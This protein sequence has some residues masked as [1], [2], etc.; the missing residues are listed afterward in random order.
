VKGWQWRLGLAGVIVFAL[1]AVMAS[2]EEAAIASVETQGTAFAVRL[3]DGRVL[4]QQELVGAVLDVSDDR[5]KSLTVRIDGF[6]IDPRDPEQEVVLYRLMVLGED[7]T[8]RELCN[9]DPAGERWAFPLAGVWTAVSE[10]Q[11]DPRAFNVTCSSGAIGKC[12]RLGYKPWKQLPDG[13]ALWDY[14]QAC[15]RMLRADYCGDGQSFTRDGTLIDLYDRLGIQKG[16]PTPGMRFEAGWG[17]DGATCVA[18]VRIPEKVM[19]EELTRRCPERLAGHVGAGC[20]EERALQ[21][22]TTL[23]LNKS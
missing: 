10:H 2:A 18:R 7:G 14:H 5:G 12:V 8:W 4:G 6:A 3:T 19:L 13:T 20:T 15:V 22:P 17:K 23:L 1:Q 11:A 21:S 16:E 9:P